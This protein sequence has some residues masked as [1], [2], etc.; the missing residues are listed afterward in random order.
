MTKGEDQSQAKASGATKTAEMWTA[1]IPLITAFDQGDSPGFEAASDG[2]C[3]AG[4]AAWRF[5]MLS[6]I[7]AFAIARQTFRIAAV[8]P[9]VQA[10]AEARQE[11]KKPATEVAGL[12]IYPLPRIN[13]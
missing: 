12:Q 5:D 3:S 8:E 7:D 9:A 10:S 11:T 4:A 1:R 6:I 2:R 13:V